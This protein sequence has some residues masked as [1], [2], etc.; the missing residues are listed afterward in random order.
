MATGRPGNIKETQLGKWMR[1]VKKSELL[2]LAQYCRCDV[3][4]LRVLAGVHREN[5]RIRFA[6]AIVTGIEIINHR[7]NS[8]QAKLEDCYPR[9]TLADLASPTRL[10]DTDESLLPMDILCKD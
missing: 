10:S 8:R 1:T 4:A 3:Y 7:H 6:M 5:P 2:E 9:V